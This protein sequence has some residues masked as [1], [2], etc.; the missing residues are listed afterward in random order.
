MWGVSESQDFSKILLTELHDQQ[1]FFSPRLHSR[2][3]LQCFQVMVGKKK[4]AKKV[5][6]IFFTACQPPGVKGES[7]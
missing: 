7:I 6:V 2:Q 5:W 4:V 3:R 1:F